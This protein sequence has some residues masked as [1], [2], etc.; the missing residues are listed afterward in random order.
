[1]CMSEVQAREMAGNVGTFRLVTLAC[2]LLQVLKHLATRAQQFAQRPRVTA[3][4]SKLCSAVPKLERPVNLC[5]LIDLGRP[6]QTHVCH[7]FEPSHVLGCQSM[8]DVCSCSE[9]TR[10]AACVF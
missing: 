1:M 6:P 4:H 2:R 8:S 3:S 9:V 10:G 5:Q 7:G